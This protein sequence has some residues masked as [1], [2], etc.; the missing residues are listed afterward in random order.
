MMR[1]NARIPN[2]NMGRAAFY[3]NRSIQEGLM[4]QALEKSS[5][6]LG[7]KPAMTQFGTQ[8]NQ[9]EF[10]GIPVRGVDQ[11]GIAETLVS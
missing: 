3:A 1:A 6:A 7:I 9:L 5:S 8:I 11:L 4:I 2:L 10:M